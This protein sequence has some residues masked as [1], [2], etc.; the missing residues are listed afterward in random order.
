MVRVISWIVLQTAPGGELFAASRTAVF[1]FIKLWFLFQ[2]TESNIFVLRYKTFIR[3]IL[4][5]D[6][7]KQG[8]FAGAIPGNKGYFL[9]FL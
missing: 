2:E 9:P 8:S 6:Y 7:P 1:L 4:S 5:C 3:R